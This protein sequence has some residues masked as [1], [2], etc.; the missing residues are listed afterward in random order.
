MGALLL[1][2]A[3]A[4]AIEPG[5]FVQQ[6]QLEGLD[7]LFSAKTVA[8][9]A[10]ALEAGLGMALLTGLRQL[11]VLI[12]GA[13]LV[14]FFLLLTARNYWLVLEGLRDETSSCGCFGSLLERTPGEALWQDLFLLVEGLRDETS[15]CGCFGSLLERT[16]GEA[17]WQDLF[18]LVPPLLLAFWNRQPPGGSLP[19]IR[20]LLSAVLAVGVVVFAAQNPDIH[21]VEIAAEIGSSDPEKHFS[22]TEDYRLFD[23]ELEIPEAEIYGSEV[24]T[25]ILILVPQVSTPILLEPRTGSLQ[26]VSEDHVLKTTGGTI[27]LAPGAALQDQGQFEMQMNGIVFSVGNS[28]FRLTS[29]LPERTPPQ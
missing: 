16:P 21:F 6:V 27:V 24:S 9:I 13:M 14:S 7:F 26:T 20:L 15:S 28:D 11:W 5:A 10:L 23:G 19:R 2:A 1:V 29:R 4:K 12:P 17:L 3:G 22:R 8:L 25:A 18:L